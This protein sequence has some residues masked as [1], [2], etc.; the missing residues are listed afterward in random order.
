MKLELFR[1][2]NYRAMKINRFSLSF[3]AVFSSLEIEYKTALPFDTTAYLTILAW[4]RLVDQSLYTGL[5]AY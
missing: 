4:Y 3:L 5:L 1:W 2:F